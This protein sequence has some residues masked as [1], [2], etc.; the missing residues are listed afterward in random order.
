MRGL[1]QWVEEPTPE[2][3]RVDP[4]LGNYK[5]TVP[6]GLHLLRVHRAYNQKRYER[7]VLPRTVGV[8]RP[9]NA[10]ELVYLAA[11]FV[12]ENSI[13]EEWQK[14]PTG[15][16]PKNVAPYVPAADPDFD[17]T[18]HLELE[19]RAGLTRELGFAKDSRNPQ[20]P[21]A[22]GPRWVYVGE[23]RPTVSLEERLGTYSF[24]SGRFDEGEAL[25]FA[26]VTADEQTFHGIDPSTWIT[27][28][29]NAAAA[30]RYR[31]P[32]NVWRTESDRYLPASPWPEGSRQPLTSA[33]RKEIVRGLR[34]GCVRN[35][36]ER[37][38]IAAA[39]P[40]DPL[41]DELITALIGNRVFGYP[42]STAAPLPKPLRKG[43]AE[44]KALRSAALF[45]LLHGG[46][47]NWPANSIS[48]ARCGICGAFVTS[49]EFLYYHDC[50][51]HLMQQKG[52][53]VSATLTEHI[54]AAV[55]AEN[56]PVLAKLEEL[57]S[58]LITRHGHPAEEARQILED[59]AA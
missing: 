32:Q 28:G 16:R 55:R 24:A 34:Y 27:G 52:L 33:A 14:F 56:E 6:D 19:L 37:Q 21:P 43:R 57:I 22:D 2:L 38:A 36:W 4:E 58:Y 26:E 7:E 47:W 29:P 48:G 18:P 46:F 15:G 49:E 51:V 41:V 39:P 23:E 5:R 35:E 30:C 25:S 59:E 44:R 8:P 31:K 40:N 11:R 17:W 42:R 1:D 3:A 12:A 13:S 9:A 54:R 20:Y 10:E 53:K 50:V 45:P